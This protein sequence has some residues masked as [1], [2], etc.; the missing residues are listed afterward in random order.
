MSA[1]LP[2]RDVQLPPAPSWWPPAPGY[3]MIGAALATFYVVLLALSEQIAFAAAYTVA[4]SSVVLIVGGYAAAVLRARRAGLILGGALA[5]GALLS[6]WRAHR[7]QA[8]QLA[9]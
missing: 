6:Q 2:L 7:L 5:L 8:R 3:L 9:A 4:A 1:S